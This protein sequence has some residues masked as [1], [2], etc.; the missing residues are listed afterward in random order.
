MLSKSMLLCAALSFVATP[1]FAQGANDKVDP[2]FDVKSFVAPV[3]PPLPPS[4]YIM[5]GAVGG[6]TQSPYT[7]PFSEYGQRSPPAPGLRLTIPTR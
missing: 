4:S 5:P 6:V 2:R 1:A 3:L 7:N